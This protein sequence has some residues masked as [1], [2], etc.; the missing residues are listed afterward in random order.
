MI[1]EAITASCE[2]KR[3]WKGG[4]VMLRDT[5][6]KCMLVLIMGVVAG[7]VSP[8]RIVQPLSPSGV[9]PVTHVVVRFSNRYN[10]R[11]DT[12]RLDLDTKEVVGFEPQGAP[13]GTATAPL[14]FEEWTRPYAHT[15]QLRTSCGFICV[16]DTQTITFKVPVLRYNDTVLGDV[17]PVVLT[18]FAASNVY[19]GVQSTRSV[20][21]PVT[22][23]ERTG[24]SRPF[25][26]LKLGTVATDLKAPGTPIVVTIPR[27][28]T[29]GTFYVEGQAVG[30]YE[31]ELTA[32][33]TVPSRGFGSVRP[34]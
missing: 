19:V 2:A 17:A 31:L 22:V 30:D 11:T 14:T 1:V 29:R 34:R 4:G 3:R 18:Q 23:M 26:I 7:C 13:G 9:D 15:L 8:V 6:S 12:W 25:P 24:P 21:I 20:D 16:Y 10:P 33:G 28:G 27:N 5:A 32:L